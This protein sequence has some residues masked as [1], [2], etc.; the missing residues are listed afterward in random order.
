MGGLLI[1]AIASLLGGSSLGSVLVGFTVEDWLTIAAGV[2]ADLLPVLQSK[3][4]DKHPAIAA[5]LNGIEQGLGAEASA[6]LAHAYFDNQ[7]PTIKGYDADGA[8]VD[9]PNPDYRG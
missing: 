6:K 3:L 9:I 4:A 7:P 5:M 1:G 2:G 8:V